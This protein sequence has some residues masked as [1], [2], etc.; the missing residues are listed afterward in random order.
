[1]SQPTQ[2]DREALAL[3]GALVRASQVT[4]EELDAASEGVR[5]AYRLSIHCARILRG[6]SVGANVPPLPVVT[7]ANV[8]TADKLYAEWNAWW[9]TTLPG[10][11]KASLDEQTKRNALWCWQASTA[12]WEAIVGAWNESDGHLGSW[13]SSKVSAATASA[14]DSAVQAVKD[15]LGDLGKTYFDLKSEAFDWSIAAILCLV[16][17]GYAKRS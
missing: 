12:A 6:Q 1:M 2:Q 17:Y 5:I 4:R 13:V 3:D 16:A 11:A 8:A 9:A 10:K 14:V 15:G 7:G